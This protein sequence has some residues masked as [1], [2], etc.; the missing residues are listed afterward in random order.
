[1]ITILCGFY[2]QM[3]PS[4]SKYKT[5]HIEENAKI[6]IHNMVDNFIKN[7]NQTQMAF[8]ISLDNFQ[9]AY[10]HMYSRGKGLITKSIG[11]GLISL[12]PNVEL[13]LLKNIEFPG[14]ARQLNIYKIDTNT[15]IE[16]IATFSLV[17]AARKLCFKYLSKYPL[18]TKEI[19]DLHYF[20]GIS[21]RQT[22]S[23]GFRCTIGNQF[24][25]CVPPNRSNPK[26]SVGRR[27]LPIFD[28]RQKIVDT[29]NSNQVV[30]ISGDTGSGKTT[31]VPQYILENHA[32][33]GNECR[34]ICTQ[35]RRL[36]A[37][38]IADR[39]ALERGEPLGQTIGYQIRLESR[40]SQS[41]NLIYTTSGF[42][43]R[44]LIGG[45][46]RELFTGLTHI[47]LDEVHERD[48][49][50]DFLLIAIK[51]ALVINPM[52]KVILMSA[53]IDS[54]VFTAYFKGCPLV[55]IPGRMFPVKLYTLEDTL[56]LVGYKQM[57]FSHFE[58]MMKPPDVPTVAVN[59]NN[60]QPEVVHDLDKDTQDF[61]NEV[62]DECFRSEQE[63][64]FS[65]FFY[66]VSGESVPVDVKHSET[67]MTALMIAASKGFT[68]VV[69]TL[70][71]LGANPGIV[72][73][74]DLTAHQW[75]TR[76]NKHDCAA[77]LE[78]IT[79]PAAPA[80][81][82]APIKQASERLLLDYQSRLGDQ[83]ID[84][85]LLM[86]V[87]K[88]IH[89]K[90]PM[91]SV[92]IFL[93]GYDSI[94]ELNEN[95]TNAVHSKQLDSNVLILMLHS[96]MQPQ[97][98]KQV[99][100][101]APYGIRKIIL[102]TNISET[103]LTIDDV[104]YV[105][106]TGK[107]KQMTYDSLTGA[108]SLTATWISQACAKQR[109]GRAGRVCPG[110]C[111]R[112]YSVMRF[113]S[114]ETFTLPEILRIPLTEIALSA[115]ILAAHSSIADFLAQ[116]IHP[117][118][119]SSVAQSVRLLKRIGAL[120]EQENVT[121][122]GT[123]LVDLPVDVQLG[124]ALLYAVLLKCLDPVLTIVS[125]LSVKDPFVLPGLDTE[126]TARHTRNNFSCESF[127]D[128]MILLRVF[129]L[130]NE[131]RSLKRDR[132]FCRENFISSGSMQMICGVR[133]QILGH[134]RS[135]G[136]IQH[137]APGNI[138]E[139]NRHS[140]NWA[141]VKACL[142]AGL[143]PNISRIDRQGGNLKSR[144][145]DKLMTHKSSVLKLKGQRKDGAQIDL[146]SDWILFG[147]KSRTGRLC[148]IRY[149]T[150]VS[151]LNVA[152][153]AGPLYLPESNLVNTQSTSD[154]EDEEQA[155]PAETENKS[156]SIVKLI[157]D[158]WISFDLGEDDA[159][160]VLHMRHKLNAL[161][162]KIVQQP[163]K[164]ISTAAD[165]QCVNTIA[166]ILQIADK[167]CNM[168]QP[169]GVGQRPI[170]V[171]LN[172][173]ADDGLGMQYMQLDERKVEAQPK[174]R[175][176][177]WRTDPQPSTSGHGAAK[178]YR[179][180]TQPQSNNPPFRSLTARPP[181][182]SS[183]PSPPAVIKVDVNPSSARFFVIHADSEQQI[184]EHFRSPGNWFW[185]SEIRQQLILTNYVSKSRSF[186]FNK[187]M[188]LLWQRFPS[189]EV[190]LFFYIPMQQRFFG[191]G[192]FRS[193]SV[194]H[195]TDALS[196]KS[197]LANRWRQI[198][199]KPANGRQTTTFDQSEDGEEIADRK[200]AKMLF[201]MLM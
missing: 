34:I 1:M 30:V 140:D 117:P 116:A 133:S 27:N 49:Y 135:I 41:S 67:H 184:M 88:H 147:E 58:D 139:L 4:Y 148:M 123:L 201:D 199:F 2:F 85:D 180:P 127:S 87:V 80:P 73:A 167:S 31:Q 152:L 77:Y 186:L 75:A 32:A 78:S 47:I 95:I 144:M 149:N 110:V 120:D 28:Y 21:N 145:D 154:S 178:Q 119:S 109:M 9:R 136:L 93:P 159:N 36:A 170:G 63:D 129:Q 8:P 52:L 83:E 24:K 169:E 82:Q 84:H 172:L 17:P 16:E 106:D 64:S 6:Y 92:L 105:V 174:A 56:S 81:Y 48:K 151:P 68:S 44:C 38:S 51:S 42:L 59:V 138:H 111:F 197:V 89:R 29:I 171:K 53:T 3:T 102:S 130:W 122:L 91:G 137:R 112:I 132:Q 100:A 150:L 96:S 76:M 43:L 157:V 61:V 158:D 104:V 90:M 37:V 69:Q 118:P 108:T 12:K 183:K 121:E 11:K 191:V 22:S 23:N 26:F 163:S 115:K 175:G 18:R 114:M 39:V 146:P 187:I 45:A 142:T 194:T 7:E 181:A 60:Q 161:F 179:A 33:M 50:T 55:D 200:A 14:S 162:L 79:K 176:G 113:D 173:G 103:S 57:K 46:Q 128:H 98:Q 13:Y 177:N 19:E 71:G 70:L 193:T 126:S 134:L 143:Y 25:L 195:Q 165:S 196:L 94:I 160:F 188:F 54:D 168:I 40:I 124:K 190:L 86:L 5:P 131:S 101:P 35:P 107:V 99:F 125:A 62:L 185:S 15:E 155:S 153:F 166:A 182:I 192:R 66:L 141:V 156:N 20:A 189:I 97:D 164:F 198:W 65:Q 72:G 10:V 74:C